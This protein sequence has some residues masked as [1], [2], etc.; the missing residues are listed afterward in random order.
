VVIGTVPGRA[1]RLTTNFDRKPFTAPR[2]MMRILF[3]EDDPRL[4]DAFVALATSLGHEA[5]AAYDGQEGIALTAA[6]EYDAV[7]MDIGL[8]DVDGR[9]LCRSL[10]HAGANQ[11][12]C[13]VAVTG[14][15][16]MTDEELA[17]FDGYLLKPVTAETLELAINGC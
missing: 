8:P 6:N 15:G 12:T 13:V 10:R 3:I 5:S 1:A 9:A 14:R 7:F 16:D 17:P 11:H 4:A 2:N